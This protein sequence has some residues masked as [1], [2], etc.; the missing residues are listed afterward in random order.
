MTTEK[1]INAKR[2]AI[3]RTLSGYPFPNFQN[4]KDSL[5]P[6]YGTELAYA[7]NFANY[8][9][10]HAELREYTEQYIKEI[11]I[12]GAYYDIKKV[13]DW[14]FFHIGIVAW[15][16]VKG[17]YLEPKTIQSLDDKLKN[18]TKKYNVE[19]VK[20]RDLKKE[21]T[22]DLMGELDGVLDDVV[23][24]RTVTQPFKHIEAAGVVDVDKIKEHF[25]AQLDE[26]NDV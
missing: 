18:L 17:A 25:Q 12:S 16:Y 7:Y 22:Y 6:T 26:V 3:E 1:T 11:G 2:K 9:Y 5:F 14:E 21:R 10:E 15:L 23:L 20:P 19:E 13:P 4:L 8:T 24:K